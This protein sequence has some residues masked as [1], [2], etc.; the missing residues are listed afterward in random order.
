[1][2][3]VKRRKTESF[4][5]LLRRFT[6]RVQ[7]SGTVIQTKKN[8]FHKDQLNHTEVRKSA[9]RRKEM[10]EKR[11]YLERSGKLKEEV[12]EPIKRF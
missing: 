2:L 12:R 8:R 11:E 7:E 3:D 9:L 1:M 5:S 4:E 10:R 6:R